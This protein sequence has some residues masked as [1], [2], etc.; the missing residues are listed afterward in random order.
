MSLIGPMRALTTS[1]L[2]KNR[3][4][5]AYPIIQ[6]VMPDLTFEAWRRFAESLIAEDACQAG[7]VTVDNEQGYIVGI[8]A[9]RLEQDLRGSCTLLIDHVAAVDL[10]RREEVAQALV[11]ELE[12]LA[13]RNG[14][15]AVDTR[16]PGHGAKPTANWLVE[17]MRAR[18]HD[19]SQLL[20]HK[21]LAKSA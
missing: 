8:A 18:G 19:V 15:S 13:L 3:I 12:H 6:M 4:G 21:S 14:C 5:Q 11:T 1:R 2:T 17:L 7:I 10:V 20:L 16:L 9:Y